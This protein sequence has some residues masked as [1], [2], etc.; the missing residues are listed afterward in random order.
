[1]GRR[2]TIAAAALVAIAVAAGL[3]AGGVLWPNRIPA[4]GYEVRG[5]DVS[6]YQ[7]A[8]DWPVLAEQDLDFAVIKATEGRAF[9]DERF[10]ANWADAHRTDLAVGAYH[11]VTFEATAEEQLANVIAA[12]P[13]VDGALP[14]TV[15]LEFYGEHFDAPPSAEHVRGIV[16]PLLAGLEE[17]YGAPPILYTTAE[18]YERY[19]R[20]RYPANPIWIRDVVLPPSLPDGRDWTIWQYS[21]RDRLPG[22][23]GVEPFIDMNVLEGGPERLEEL[24]G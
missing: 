11:F 4:A 1:M 13:V 17:H 15:D 22:Y 14:V 5:V 19:V 10:R 8:I 23:D 9:V 18:A 12:V 6:A 2:L 21:N 24:L 7:G 16:D 3:V 20:N